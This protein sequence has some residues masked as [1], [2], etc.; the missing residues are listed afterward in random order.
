M[1]SFFMP[2]LV[3]ARMWCLFQRY[4]HYSELVSLLSA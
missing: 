3:S 2:I 1:P 4:C